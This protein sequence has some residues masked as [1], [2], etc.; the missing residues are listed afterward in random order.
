MK[1]YLAYR[2]EVVQISQESVR[3]DEARLRHVL[4]W[5]DETLI[6]DALSIR[7]TLPDYLETARIDGRKDTLSPAYK[8][9]IINAAHQFGTWLSVYQ[10][11][12]KTSLFVWLDTLRIPRTL[13]N[14]DRQHEAVTLAEIEQIAAAPAEALWEKRI[15]ASAV[16]WFLSGIR[17]GAF[18]TLPIAAVNIEARKI[19]QWPELGVN[20]KFRKRSTTYM[21]KIPHLLE[22]VREW[23]REV[24]RTVPQ[25]GYWFAPLSNQTGEIKAEGHIVGHHRDSRARVDLKRWLE[26]VDLPYRSPHKFRHGFAVYALKLA[27]DM[28]DFKA[29]SMNLMHANMSITDGIY[30][31]LSEQDISERITSLGEQGSSPDELAKL[32][33]QLAQQ[34]EGRQ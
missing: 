32:L 26:S 6:K 29:I 10:N 1:A 33:R 28:A 2:E 5:A 11:G 27:Q 25:T 14:H 20:T 18:V 7:P 22:A 12:Y 31:V 23:D 15:R 17:I 8:Q 4:E 24:R 9:K 21:L 16:F 13:A 19:R 34:L 3:L 30:A